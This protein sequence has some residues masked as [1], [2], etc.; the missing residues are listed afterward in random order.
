MNHQI[1][2]IALGLAL[3]LAPGIQTLFSQTTQTITSNGNWIVPGGVYS[4]TVEAIGG[5]GGGGNVE[6]AGRAGGGG[7]G[8]AYARS[9]IAVQPGQNFLITIGQGGSG[10]NSNKNGGNTSFGSFVIAA[11]GNGAGLNSTN[12]GLGG[13]LNNSTGDVAFNGGNGGNGYGTSCGSGAGGGGSAGYS[14]QNGANGSNGTSG[15]NGGAGGAGNGPISGSGGSGAGSNGNGNSGTNYGSGGGGGKSPCV[16]GTDRNG[17]NGTQGV[18]RITYSCST[19]SAFTQITGPTFVCAGNSVTINAFGGNVNPDDEILWFKNSCANFITLHEF[20]STTNPVVTNSTIQAYHSGII[21]VSSTSGDPNI[22]LTNVISQNVTN[23]PYVHFRYRVISGNAGQAELYYSKNGGSDLSESQVVRTNLISDGQWHV[24]SVLMTTS[25][26]YSGTITGFRFDYATATNV[27][28]EIDYITLTNSELVGTNASLTVSPTQTTTYYAMRKNDCGASQC[29]P[30]IIT[31]SSFPNTFSSTLLA[32]MPICYNSQIPI[33]ISPSQNGITYQLQ[34]DGNLVGSTSAGNGSNLEIM[35]PNL[36]YTPSSIQIIASNALGCTTAVNNSQTIS[37]SAPATQLANDGDT[38][39]CYINGNNAYVEFEMNGRAIGAIHPG[40]QNLGNVTMQEFVSLTPIN[41]QA[42]GTD[43]I[44]EPQF[45]T[46]ALNRH[47]LI[48]ASNPPSSPVNL[49]LYIDQ[50]DFNSLQVMSN[51]NANLNDNLSTFQ[52]LH[53]NKYNGPNEN[54]SI[55]DNCGQG[56]STNIFVSTSNGPINTALIGGAGIS[57]GMHLTYSIPGFSEFWLSGTDQISPLPIVLGNFNLECISN[58][59]KIKW[60]SVSEINNDYYIVERSLNGKDYIQIQT[61]K[62]AGNSNSIL[63]YEVIDEKSPRQTA[64]YR[65]KQ[66]D[67][68][69]TSETFA[70][71]SISCFENGSADLRIFPNP[72]QGEFNMEFMSNQTASTGNISVIDI[73][74]KQV[75]LENISIQEGMN[76]RQINITSLKT[77]TY[78]LLINSNSGIRYQKRFIISN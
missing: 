21:R 6:T 51:N 30:H 48:S 12:A 11:G 13:S 40:T 3:M 68:N 4:I 73:M 31:Y 19:P 43:P 33:N 61:I 71:S 16:G 39:T 62:G 54:N 34:I 14:T 23:Y 67:F 52:S 15:N 42:C 20:N 75:Y 1:V 27:T 7:G 72:N 74:G 25:A 26:N 5:G 47:W 22:N 46:A 58:G 41:V 2:K 32:T 8:G 9:T 63:N 38:R 36:N 59:V 64:Y 10:S 49:R 18:V 29:I 53:L 44:N 50:A 77:G 66:V 45:N 24:A 56:G 76:N 17:G 65:L 35:T 60:T 70:P 28:I 57:S 78:I 37:I 69:G 55:L